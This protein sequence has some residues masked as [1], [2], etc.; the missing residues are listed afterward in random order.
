MPKLNLKTLD[1]LNKPNDLRLF[2][3]HSPDVLYHLL[4][5]LAPCIPDKTAAGKYSATSALRN[6]EEEYRQYVRLFLDKK[7]GEFLHPSQI[8]CTE[9]CAAVPYMLLAYKH[10]FDIPYMAWDR[11]DPWFGYMLPQSLQW[12]MEDYDIPTG[13]DYRAYRE[14][15][16][17]EA[18]NA[19]ILPIHRY[20]F[21]RT[22][23]ADFD[24]LPAMLKGMILQTWIYHPSL[25]HPNM[26]TDID[27][28]DRLAEPLDSETVALDPLQ[29]K[30]PK[31]V[32]EVPKKP[33]ID[34]PW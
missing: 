16:L 25:R 34:T 23:D 30:K 14:L 12:L 13:L 28:W 18:K 10:Q 3:A 17:Y 7:V 6:L 33:D 26:I 20:K 9:M 1:V 11:N 8:R 15:V 24:A 5:H 21:S 27:N 22:G 2:K 29:E 31:K 4:P 19:V 32:I